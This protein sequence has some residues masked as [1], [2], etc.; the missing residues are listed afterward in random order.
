MLSNT[1]IS[2][3]FLPFLLK[4][5]NE[6]VL[7]ILPG[8]L[9]DTLPMIVLRKYSISKS[10]CKL[11]FPVS[12]ASSFS[13]IHYTEGVAALIAKSINLQPKVN[14]TFAITQTHYNYTLPSSTMPV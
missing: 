3:S 7:Y 4:V 8:L 14:Y 1:N 6:A 12:F 13:F 10:L 5:G 11:Y 9:G 2:L